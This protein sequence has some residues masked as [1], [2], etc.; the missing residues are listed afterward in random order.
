MNSAE[1]VMWTRP[2]SALATLETIDTLRLRTESQRARFSLLYTMALNRNWIDTTDLHL[3]LPAVSYYKNHG[4]NDDKMMT[5]YYLGTV[6]HNAGNPEDAIASYVRALEYSSESDNLIFK[7][8]IASAISD[9][10]CQEQNYSASLG[11]ADEALTLFKKAEDSTRMW[12]TTAMMASILG[13]MHN[14]EKSDSLYSEFF[15][16]SCHDSS[17]YARMLL[18]KALSYLWK[19]NPEP[20]LSIDLFHKSVNEFNGSPTTNDYCAYAYALELS[21]NSSAADIIISQL[22]A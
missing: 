10:Y 21:G 19:S 20:D 16:S 7:G 12:V 9:L 1:D 11:Y 17:L 8:L 18:N 4:S 2:D 14:Y 22:E 15:S 5:F 13:S 6:Q 3:I